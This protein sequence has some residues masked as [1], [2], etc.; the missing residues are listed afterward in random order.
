MPDIDLC[1]PYNDFGPGF[2]CTSDADAAGQWAC[3]RGSSGFI[4]RYDINLEFLKVLDLSD[5]GNNIL[6]WLAVVLENRQ[7]R[8]TSPN[9][10]RFLEHIKR[11][12][13]PDVDSAD[14]II[15]TRCDDSYFSFVRMF[16]NGK[17]SYNQLKAAVSV[18]PASQQIVIRSKA[19]FEELQF[20]SCQRADSEVYYPKRKIKDQSVKA[21]CFAD[22]QM[23]DAF[24]IGVLDI[25]KEEVMPGDRRL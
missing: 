7:F 12:F 18:G 22:A 10:R 20:V 19:A 4:N 13:R 11:N 6:T 21:K 8:I 14:V 25:L 17:I 24:G 1:V 2:Y 16:L 3:S 15:G 23:G 9:V 5:S